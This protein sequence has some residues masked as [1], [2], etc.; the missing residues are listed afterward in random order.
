MQTT[1]SGG[2]RLTGAITRVGVFEYTHADGRKLLEYRPP[3]EVLAPAS[4]ASFEGAAVTDLHPDGMVTPETFRALVRGHVHD[5]REAGLLVEANVDVDD[6]ELIK[7]IDAG[8]RREISSGYTA[9]FDPTPGVT[10]D[11]QHYDG[12][13]RNIRGNHVAVGPPGWGRLGPSVSLR[14]DAGSAIATCITVATATSTRQDTKETTMN[15][16]RIDGIEYE[17]GSASHISALERQVELAKKRADDA[18]AKVTVEAKRADAAEATVKTRDTEVAKQTA[19]A[20]AADKSAEPKALAKRIAERVYLV[21]LART[22]LGPTYLKDAAGDEPGTAMAGAN[23]DDIIRAILKQL[24][25]ALDSKAMDHAALMGALQVACVMG[26]GAAT[27]E[28]PLD[29]ASESTDLPL[30][31]EEKKPTA[32]DARHAPRGQIGV[33]V[34]NQNA[35]TATPEIRTQEQAIAERARKDAARW[36]QPVLTAPTR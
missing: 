23:D 8:T 19:R 15:K 4:I 17:V 27:T 33:V 30:P 20:D 2:R 18:E 34:P 5:P 13:Q 1:P 35:P 6:A 26:G 28:L 3:E 12:V 11:G 7:M 9:D 25:P 29:A 31:G 10:P 14:L 16:I 36:K 21:T 22:H 24:A 32:F